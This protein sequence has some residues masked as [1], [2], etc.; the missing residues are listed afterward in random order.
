MNWKRC[1]RAFAEVSR[2]DTE[3]AALG[4]S[5]TS[6]ARRCLRLAG[7]ATRKWWT[8]SLSIS[9][10][11][12]IGEGARCMRCRCLLRGTWPVLSCSSRLACFLQSVWA[13]E[14]NLFEGR[15]LEK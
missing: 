7:Q 9:H 15:E 14:R 11:G 12:Q 1:G 8:V 3:E 2:L 13:S 5:A 4:P 6:I 10:A